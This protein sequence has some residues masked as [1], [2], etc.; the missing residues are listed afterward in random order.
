MRWAIAEISSKNTVVLEGLSADESN[1]YFGT[2]SVPD[3]GEY[4]ASTFAHGA[5]DLDGGRVFMG[6]SDST[7]LGVDP[8]GDTNGGSD[9]AGG[10]DRDDRSDESTEISA[11]LG[12]V[13]LLP[14]LLLVAGF[15]RRLRR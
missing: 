5:D 1:E 2:I 10:A 12:A 6:L 4:N 14:T 3:E 13:P 9:G 11:P 15:V 8:T 7:S